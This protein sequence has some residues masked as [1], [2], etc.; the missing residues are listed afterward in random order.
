MTCMAHHAVHPGIDHSHQA[1][2]AGFYLLCKLVTGERKQALARTHTTCTEPWT[3]LYELIPMFDY[4]DDPTNWGARPKFPDPSKEKMATAILDKWVDNH[5]FRL[6]G[7]GMPREGKV[8][9]LAEALLHVDDWDVDW[10]DGLT[11]KEIKLV[12]QHSEWFHEFALTF[13]RK[14]RGCSWCKKL[15]EPPA[16]GGDDDDDDEGVKLL[17]CGGCKQVFYCNRE[18]QIAHWKKVHKK[19]CKLMRSRLDPNDPS[20]VSVARALDD[21]VW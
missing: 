18:C 16:G 14:A 21:V 7:E 15:W 6:K 11:A 13:F 3:T 9:D 17:T 4:G 10:K 19:Q 20:S 1:H 2:G 5:P 12:R 8:I